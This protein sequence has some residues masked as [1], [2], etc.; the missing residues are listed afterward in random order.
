LPLPHRNLA[1]ARCWT[2]ASHA[3]AIAQPIKATV[4][5]SGAAW[6]FV[7]LPFKFGQDQGWPFARLTLLLRRAFIKAKAEGSRPIGHPAASLTPAR[8]RSEYSRPLTHG[9]IR[10]KLNRIEIYLCSRVHSR[11][12]FILIP[13]K[14]QS[15]S[16]PCGRLKPGRRETVSAARW[17][18]VSPH[19]EDR[20]FV[21]LDHEGPAIAGSYPSRRSHFALPSG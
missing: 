13:K 9:S 21:H 11:K 12:R 5:P 19:G 2:P 20:I 6:A 15:R 3:S 1:L 8:D 16:W 17:R 10:L 14:I 4:Y 7:G 18:Q